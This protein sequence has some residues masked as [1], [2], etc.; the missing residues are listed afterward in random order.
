VK[1]KLV[2]ILETFCPDN[3]FLQGTRNPNEAYPHELLT[4]WTNSTT[5]RAHYDNEADSV[6]WNFYVMYYADDPILV[7]TKPREIATKLKAA[8]FVQQGIG[9]DIL[10]DEQ[11]HTGWAMEFTY[12]EKLITKEN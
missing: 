3:V 12:S 5:R 7:A 9:Y 11:T 8:G 4:F 10:S 2:D 6:D 1:Q